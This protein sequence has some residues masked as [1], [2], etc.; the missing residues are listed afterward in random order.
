MDMD[1]P[2][3]AP[4]TG[5]AMWL[6]GFAFF[7]SIYGAVCLYDPTSMEHPVHKGHAMPDGAYNPK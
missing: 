5:L 4:W 6:G 2:N 7:G 1:S 3:V